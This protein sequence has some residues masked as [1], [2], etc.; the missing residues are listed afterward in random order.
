MIKF[1]EA[2]DDWFASYISVKYPD[3]D[4]LKSFGY[5]EQVFR[6][7]DNK[8]TPLIVTINGTSDRLSATLDDRYQICTWFR[9]LTQVSKQN[10]IQN[11]D[12]S[13]GFKDNPVQK[14]TLFWFLAWRVELGEELP[15]TLIE[16]IPGKLL[17]E[18]YSFASIDRSSITIDPDHEK[19]YRQELGDTVY[20][21]H[22]FLW[23]IVGITTNLEYILNP[24]CNSDGCE[25]CPDNSFITQDGDCL[26]PN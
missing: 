17:V 22:R 25:E 26:I 2:L 4:F 3:P 11:N 19:I 5:C 9:T 16:N 14:V 7:I 6:T 23:N 12:W 8:S 15:F 18:G 13:F 20:E 1:I 24:N 10:T 21:K